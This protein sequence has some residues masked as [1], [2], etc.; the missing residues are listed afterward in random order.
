MDPQVTELAFHV[1]N[2]EIRLQQVCD[3]SNVCRSSAGGGIGLLSS[4]IHCG[5]MFKL[6][7]QFSL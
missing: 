5:I 6:F 1:N 2:Q 4:S 7:F 3:H